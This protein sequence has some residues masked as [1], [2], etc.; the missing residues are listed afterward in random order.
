MENFID[1][2]GAMKVTNS[3]TT[4]VDREAIS[5]K[6]SVVADQCVAA[7]PTTFNM[8]IVDDSIMNRKML[9]R[10]L[11]A[12]GHTC[13]VAV[14]GLE[15]L[16]LVM[17]KNDP[18]NGQPFDVILMDF[19]MPNMDGPTATKEIRSLGYTAPIFGVTGNG[20]YVGHYRANHMNLAF[21][22]VFI[23]VYHPFPST[24]GSPTDV[25]HFL[26]SGANKVIL[27]PFRI[28]AF[29]EAMK[30]IINQHTET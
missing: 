20:E 9:Q 8:L 24:S 12:G 22:T 18:S 27:K 23:T 1:G 17:E 13:T 19:E 14:D 2:A 7:I 16:A 15:A 5:P 4:A 21:V 10:C 6:E 3:E 11:S 30:A 25:Q 29:G 26:S 28:G